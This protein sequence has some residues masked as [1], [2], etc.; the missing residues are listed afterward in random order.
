MGTIL[1]LTVIIAA[2]VGAIAV[3]LVTIHEVVEARIFR[4]L[5]SRYG[6][7]LNAENRT[8]NLL[9]GYTF[10]PVEL[11]QPSQQADK[12]SGDFKTP[13]LTVH[14]HL[15][16][17]QLTEIS[18]DDGTYGFVSDNRVHDE[19]AVGHA[20]L[21]PD[22]SGWLASEPFKIG[23]DE[24]DGSATLKIRRDGKEI[25]GQIVI[26]HLPSRYIEIAGTAPED[27]RLPA[28][29][30]VSINLSGAPGNVTVSGSV[31]DPLT[32]NTFRF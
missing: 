26:N 10:K 23:P 25:E 16:P 12:P 22:D 3:T 28:E 24:W 8:G 14:W 27:F 1:R 30:I 15:R 6:L 7:N 21:L 18:W 11:I 29:V 4:D 32:R 17:F 13:R 19:I 2:I 20:T 9:Y 5:A 31:S